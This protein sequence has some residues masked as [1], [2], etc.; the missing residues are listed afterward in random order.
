MYAPAACVARTRV[1]S[2]VG[3][4]GVV[5]TPGGGQRC[6]YDEHRPSGEAGKQAD[7]HRHEMAR[8]G[9]TSNA[10]AAMM[11]PIHRMMATPASAGMSHVRADIVPVRQTS[12]IATPLSTE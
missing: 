8:F 11:M 12:V 6:L 2:S 9:V 4:P 10:C 5:P 3:P 1:G 7:D